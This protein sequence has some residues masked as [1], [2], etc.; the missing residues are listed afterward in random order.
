MESEA[1]DGCG[2]D[3]T[4]CDAVEAKETAVLEGRTAG[5]A[6][7]ELAFAAGE[8]KPWLCVLSCDVSEREARWGGERTVLAGVGVEVF[9]GK[10]CEFAVVWC[11]KCVKEL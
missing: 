2:R 3:V 1:R 5:V 4:V 11:Y 7:F 9:G 6:A 8:G 10:G